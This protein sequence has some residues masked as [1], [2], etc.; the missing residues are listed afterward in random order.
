MSDI[1]H[2]PS[3]ERNSFG[4]VSSVVNNNEPYSTTHSGSFYIG[5]DLET[6]AA[7]S[8]DQIFAG[9]NSN[10]EDIFCVLNFAANASTPTVRFDAFAQYDQVIIFE[11]GTSYVKF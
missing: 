5:I 10:T 3:I 9:Y 11:N 2:A 1:N 8:K 7:A 4:L 6:Y